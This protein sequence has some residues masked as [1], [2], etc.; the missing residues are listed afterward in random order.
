MFRLLR[1]GFIA[2]FI[3]LSFL[4]ITG[5]K[6]GG[7]TVSEYFQGMLS[8]KEV[9]EGLKDVKVLVGEAMKAVGSEL[10]DEMTDE[11][12]KALEKIVKVE[13]QEGK[14][15]DEKGVRHESLPPEKRK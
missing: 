15:V 4:A 5:Q 2:G 7:K 3:I 8:N 12:R 9:S 10:A 14:P 6:I 11:D 1:W 13:L